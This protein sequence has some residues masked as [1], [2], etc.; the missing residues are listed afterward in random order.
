MKERMEAS[1]NTETNSSVLMA[2]CGCG[3]VQMALSAQYTK[4]SLSVLGMSGDSHPCC[5]VRGF[6]VDVACKEHSI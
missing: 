4:Y 5:I 2:E 3:Y 6:R 1:S